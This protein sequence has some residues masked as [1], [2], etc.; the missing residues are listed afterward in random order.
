LL[1]NLFTLL[2]NP[3]LFSQIEEVI[4]PY[5]EFDVCKRVAG[6]THKHINQ[7]IQDEAGNLMISIQHLSIQ[8]SFDQKM[9]TSIETYNIYGQT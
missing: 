8:Y 7:K 3:I 4:F 6:L 9:P 2:F 1:Y 5:F